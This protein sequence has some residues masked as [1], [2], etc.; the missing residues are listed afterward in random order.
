MGLR[1]RESRN[2][3]DRQSRI[4]CPLE[5]ERLPDDHMR[6][7][8]GYESL[9][10]AIQIVLPPASRTPNGPG[11]RPVPPD[12]TGD[13]RP[14]ITMKDP[15]RDRNDDG[16]GRADDVDSR[17]RVLPR[18]VAKSLADVH[19]RGNPWE[20]R[21]LFESARRRALP[22]RWQMIVSAQP[23]KQLLRG[24][25]CLWKERPPPRSGGRRGSRGRTSRQHD[26]AAA[27]AAPGR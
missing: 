9:Q 22:T 5:P 21:P 3:G 12:T 25:H 24:A 6:A 16:S 18:R 8:G 23:P 2:E 13:R 26:A 1:S 4:R 14:L 19:S 7:I 20:H 10:M 17:M 15:I 11:R 27:T